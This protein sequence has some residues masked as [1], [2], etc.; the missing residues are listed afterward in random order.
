MVLLKVL[1]LDMRTIMLEL[2]TFQYGSIKG[3]AYVDENDDY[4]VDLHS[5][6][7]LL[8]GYYFNNYNN[9]LPIYIPIWFY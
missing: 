3:N 7:V 5:N 4:H 6:M 8:K 2:F 1:E 9:N